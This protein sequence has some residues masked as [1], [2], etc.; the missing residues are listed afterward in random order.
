MVSWIGFLSLCLEWVPGQIGEVAGNGATMLLDHDLFTV[1]T[2]KYFCLLFFL[3]H[4]KISRH[5]LEMGTAGVNVSI[6]DQHTEIHNHLGL[7]GRM[8]NSRIKF[9]KDHCGIFELSLL[10]KGYV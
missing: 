3:G 1:E 10:P 4:H 6:V 7:Q 9:R 5:L 8:T 2:I